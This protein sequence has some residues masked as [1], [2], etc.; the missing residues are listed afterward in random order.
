MRDC[1]RT[2][3]QAWDDLTEGT[4]ANAWKKIVTDEVIPPKQTAVTE[5]TSLLNEIQSGG[6]P[7]TD[8]D[9]EEWL[10]VDEG[11]PTW[12]ILS[13]EQIIAK[14]NGEEFLELPGDEENHDDENEQDDSCEEVPNPREVLAAMDTINRW[15]EHRWERQTADFQSL[16]KMRDIAVNQ[17]LSEA[18][19]SHLSSD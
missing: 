10:Q 7:Y 2:I 6:A 9:A 4:L 11:C 14:A 18:K 8:N 3:A 13:D 1:C 12:Q 17:A 16:R 19:A 5:V 15:Y